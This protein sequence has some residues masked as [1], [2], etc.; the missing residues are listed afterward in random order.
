MTLE[1]AGACTAHM[2]MRADMVMI[3]QQEEDRQWRLATETLI[4]AKSVRG[5]RLVDLDCGL[6]SDNPI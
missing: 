3:V 4:K 2:M 6:L 1:G 5:Y